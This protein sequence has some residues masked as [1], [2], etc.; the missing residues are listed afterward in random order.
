MSEEQKKVLDEMA[1]LGE[2]IEAAKKSYEEE[3][4]AWWNSLSKE[5]QMRAFYS[6]V[7]R[8]VQGEISD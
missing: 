7:K 6:V 3:N 8:L 4:D 2:T 1:R 5:E